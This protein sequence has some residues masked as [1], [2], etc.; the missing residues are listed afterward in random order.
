MAQ[1]Q[2]DFEYHAYEAKCCGT[3]ENKSRKTIYPSE[4][5]GA[6]FGARERRRE[7]DW[8]YK[9]DR[10]VSNTGLCN[11]PNGYVRKHGL[12]KLIKNG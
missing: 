8:C 4:Q 6:H 11:L 7:T 5:P 12:G 10:M 2:E 3:C 9:I 1:L